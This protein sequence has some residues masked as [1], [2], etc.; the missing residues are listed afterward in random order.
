MKREMRYFMKEAML[1]EDRLVKKVMDVEGSW[2]CWLV[3]G[4]SEFGEQIRD[5]LG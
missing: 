2:L 5:L 1:D 4:I 3:G